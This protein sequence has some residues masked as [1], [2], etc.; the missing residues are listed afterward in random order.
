MNRYSSTF[1]VVAIAAAFHL[2]GCYSI[3]ELDIKDGRA[4]VY[5]DDPSKVLPSAQPTRDSITV[6]LVAPMHMACVQ[7]A[8]EEQEAEKYER[9]AC[10]MR[11]IAGVEPKDEWKAL[12]AAETGEKTKA[13][14]IAMN[15]GEVMKVELTEALKQY[16]RSV[17][18]NLVS[19]PPAVPD[20]GGPNPTVTFY[21]GF[22]SKQ[23]VTEL[24]DGSASGQGHASGKINPAH[25]VWF[26]PFMLATIP[27]FMWAPMMIM[28]NIHDGV[29]E[30]VIADAIRLSAQ[31]LAKK[32][33]EGSLPP[34]VAES[35]PQPESAEPASPP[36]AE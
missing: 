7:K 2:G 17:T 5:D 3:A 34:P 18:V 6:N 1:A 27:L 28:G 11:P 15:I 12:Y 24:S 14:Q 35:P 30:E 4:A 26:F 23:A 20:A 21:L 32:I 36:P 22:A 8:S 16:Y 10:P 31:D 33:A 29:S 9:T 25:M 19:E 13:G